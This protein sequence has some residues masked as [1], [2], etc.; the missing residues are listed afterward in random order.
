M[1][2]PI[3]FHVMINGN[4]ISYEKDAK[5]IFKQR[6]EMCHNEDTPGL[7]WLD[8]NQAKDKSKEIRD[9]VWVK[10]DMPMNNAT[11]MTEQE[12]KVIRDWVD[13]GCKK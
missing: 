5:P 9:H 7:N 10:K 4:S 12:R 8:Y 2:L 1:I 6:C 3:I 13:Q 11:H